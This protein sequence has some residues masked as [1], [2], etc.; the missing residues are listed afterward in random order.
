MDKV[1][2]RG[3]LKII[4]LAFILWLFLY[5]T[6]HEIGKFIKNFFHK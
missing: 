6:G 1:K 3:I 4:V 2:I 5:F